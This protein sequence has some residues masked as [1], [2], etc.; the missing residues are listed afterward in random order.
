MSASGPP[1]LSDTLNV[2]FA[3]VRPTLAPRS[4]IL[5][6][7]WR[8]DKL[9][10]EPSEPG[11]SALTPQNI[12][13]TRLKSGPSFFSPPLKAPTRMPIH[14]PSSSKTGPPLLPCQATA[15]VA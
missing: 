9:A 7:L 2:N 10:L 13:K 3:R 1:C 6:V 14:T 4:C 12:G 11:S 15:S 5:P 8:L